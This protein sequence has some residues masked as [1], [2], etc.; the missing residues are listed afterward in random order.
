MRRKPNNYLHKKY[1]GHRDAC[2]RQRHG[3]ELTVSEEHQGDQCGWREVKE[4]QR[5]GNRVTE[6][7]AIKTGYFSK[8]DGKPLE[9]FQLRSNVNYT[10][11]RVLGAPFGEIH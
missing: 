1:F 5:V 2:G 9:G 4:E 7:T 3:K 11:Y 10:N 6:V 8:S